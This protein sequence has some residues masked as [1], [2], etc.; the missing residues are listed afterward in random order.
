MELTGWKEVTPP[1]EP[2]LAAKWKDCLFDSFL[3]LELV[4][5]FV[6]L[7]FLESYE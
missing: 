2:R 1:Q 4:K 6:R 3:A 5:S 7:R